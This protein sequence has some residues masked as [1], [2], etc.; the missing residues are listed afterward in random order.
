[1]DELEPLASAL[2][3]ELGSPPEA[4]QKAQRA[5]VR[6]A[7]R[8]PPLP[9]LRRRVVP[10]VV[11]VLALL[12][13]LIWIAS[14]QT[15]SDEIE[16]WLV[17]EELREPF[18]FEDGSSIT[19]APGGRGRLSAG[20]GAVRFDLHQGRALFDVT[21]GQRRTWMITA[22]KNEVR[23]VGTRFSVLYGPAETFQVGVH[24]GVVSVRV[25][26]RK[27][28]VELVA[29]DRLEGR[30]GHMEV[31]QGA[32]PARPSSSG[33]AAPGSSVAGLLPKAASAIATAAE[34]HQE[35][36][37][38]PSAGRRAAS[39]AEQ[40][41]GADWQARYRAGKYTES[42]ALLR[43]TGIPEHLDELAPSTLAIVADAAR[44][45]GDP[46]LAVRALDLLLRRFPRAPEARHG[47][48]L[49]GRVH[50]LRGDRAAAI[51]AFESY[52]KAGGSAAYANE[53]M[54]RLMELY[55]ARGDRESARSMA[56]RYLESAPQGPYH[57][58]ARSL[59]LQPR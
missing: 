50:V 55:S 48:F 47:R 27:A 59:L 54:G 56:R 21:P 2:R 44:L 19:L 22:G 46:A 58:L 38:L 53:A 12:G 42:L 23:V 18:R 43:T 24:R 49:L 28:S 3:R 20:A 52:L 1:M 13:A 8:E 36:A 45:G 5:R 32:S 25:P 16:R 15:R 35:A 26:D 29:G 31:V 14:R 34:P 51:S 37:A 41:S 4:W 7:L 33:Q 57:R 10:R 40:T 39:T 9:S 6:D 30:P 11:A 17:A